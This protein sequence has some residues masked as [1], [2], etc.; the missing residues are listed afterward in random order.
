MVIVFDKDYLQ[1][2]YY[3]GKCKSKKHRFQP[4]VIENYVNCIDILSSAVRIEDLFVF[5]SLNYEVLTGDKHGVS[6]I[7]IDRKY[8]LEFSVNSSGTEPLI[9]TICTIIDISNHYK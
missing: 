5:R 4:S 7:R 6:S 9:I 1:E 8:R 3:T 2:L